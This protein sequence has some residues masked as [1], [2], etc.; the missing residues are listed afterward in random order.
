MGVGG[1]Q[2]VQTLLHAG[3]QVFVNPGIGGGQTFCLVHAANLGFYAGG[4]AGE[5]QEVVAGELNEE[6]TVNLSLERENP[7]AHVERQ[8]GIAHP[9]L[10]AGYGVLVRT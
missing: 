2:L 7:L 10:G 8:H 3:T 1:A 5:A 9:G 6:G 4:I